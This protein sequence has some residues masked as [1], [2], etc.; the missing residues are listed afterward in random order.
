MNGRFDEQYFLFKESTA[1]KIVGFLKNL[2]KKLI[3]TEFS[4]LIQ[5]QID[6]F[7]DKEKPVPG[8]VLDQSI[9]KKLIKE[10]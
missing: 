1:M 4:K 6:Q 2:I 5:K 7:E 9:L 8:V 10:A 3:S